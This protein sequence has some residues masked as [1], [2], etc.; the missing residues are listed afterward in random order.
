MQAIADFERM[1][2]HVLLSE[3]WWSVLARVASGSWRATSELVRAGIL[4]E[5]EYGR[6]DPNGDQ[7]KV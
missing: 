1:R 6:P 3:G 7:A 4:P 5:R 2:N